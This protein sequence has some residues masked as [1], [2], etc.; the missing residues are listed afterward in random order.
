MIRAPSWSLF[1]LSS[2]VYYIDFLFTCSVFTSTSA[3]CHHQLILQTH[4]PTHKRNMIIQ[5]HRGTCPVVAY[6][7]SINVGDVLVKEK[8]PLIRCLL[9]LPLPLQRHP[10]SHPSHTT[11][12]DS[13]HA[14]VMMGGRELRYVAR[15]SSHSRRRVWDLYDFGQSEF[16]LPDFHNY[17]DTLW[18]QLLVIL[19]SSESC[20]RRMTRCRRSLVFATSG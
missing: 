6:I 1:S 8:V 18:H 13:Q 14:L 19:P 10:S 2:S 17:L 12:Q 15:P 5:R 16:R 9:L 4:P 11:K 3:R 7:Y 20:S